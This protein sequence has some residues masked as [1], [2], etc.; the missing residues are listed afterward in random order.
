MTH[1]KAEN[2]DMLADAVRHAAAQL[3][4]K[5]VAALASN[6]VAVASALAATATTLG[7]PSVKCGREEVI[8]GAEPVILDDAAAEARLGSHT[9][10]SREVNL[11]SSDEVAERAGV[12]SRQS[13]HDWLKKG[14]IIGWEGAK[15][16]LVFPAAQLD[17]RGRPLAGL[18]QIRPFFADGYAAWVWLTTPLRALEGD[19]PLDRL[20]ERDVEQV[21][22]A[23]LGD[24]QG[25][26]G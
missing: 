5:A 4:A 20:R 25:D 14:R 10:K 24:A 3:S 21:V 8:A 19:E 9:R 23:A 12:K 2:V 1:T 18:E 15:R 16:G 26:F 7:A 17:E 13:I 22:A 6:P 11:L